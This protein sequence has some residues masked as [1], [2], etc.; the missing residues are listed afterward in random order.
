MKEEH[1][2][3][4]GNYKTTVEIMRALSQLFRNLGDI[5]TANNWE[6]EALAEESR[7]RWKEVYFDGKVI[8]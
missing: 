6:I 3:T 4:G 7:G 5:A 8:N 1:I 2:T